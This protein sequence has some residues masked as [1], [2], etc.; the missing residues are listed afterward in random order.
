MQ[1]P[2]GI[3]I[4]Y[5]YFSGVRNGFNQTLKAGIASST[6]G[7]QQGHHHKCLVSGMEDGRAKIQ[8]KS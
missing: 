6:R 3:S 4:H 7:A 1:L 8:L 2:A 5:I